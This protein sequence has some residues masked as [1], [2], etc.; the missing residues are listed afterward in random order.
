VDSSSQVELQK[1]NDQLR[2]ILEVNNNI[3][4]NLD[5]PDLLQAIAVSVR[6]VIQCDLV[7]VALPETDGVHLRAYAHDFPDGKGLIRKNISIRIEN[8]GPGLAF[9]T[10]QAVVMSSSE[11]ARLL[12]AGNRARS[13]GL[14]SSCCLPLTSRNRVLGTLYLGRLQKDQ[15]FTQ[16]EVDFLA[17]ITTQ[18]AVAVDNALAYRQLAEEV[19]Q[20]ER[21]NR[22]VEIAR[23]VQERL[24]P[25]KFPEISGLDYCG[26]CR[27]ALGVGGDYYDFLGLPDGRLAIALGDVSGKGIAAALMMAGLQASLRSE[28]ARGPQNLA[29]VV[30]NINRQMY[31]I[32]E[33]NRYATLFYG[34]YNPATY[35]FAYVNAGHNAPLLFHNSHGKWDLSR[36]TFGGT[37]VGLLESSPYQQGTATLARGDVLIAFT[38]GVSE[39]MNNAE[40][41]WGEERL[42]EAIKLDPGFSAAQILQ[43]ALETVDA[44][45]GGAMQHDD[46]TLV[47]LR[48]LP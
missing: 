42:I 33:T 9:R 12:P 41:E 39:A 31:E 14:Q 38:D 2:L 32:S 37:V 47:V 43:H 28:V 6:R 29:A 27:P 20:R 22:E 48:A 46:M 17:Q 24:F 8:T 13:E 36:L 34:E 23:A 1:K 16:E 21:F 19:A 35:E 5:L 44:F 15:A 4:S 3:A 30:C 7:G 40:E 10:G 26:R 45:V 18:V 25:Q 11:M